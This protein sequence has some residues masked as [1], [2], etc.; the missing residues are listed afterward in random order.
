MKISI[1]ET[2]PNTLIKV[3][4]NLDFQLLSNIFLT[5]LYLSDTF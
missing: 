2:L 3:G 1:S 5:A 4:K